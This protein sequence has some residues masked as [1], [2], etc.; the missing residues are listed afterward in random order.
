MKSTSKNNN[1]KKNIKVK[2][3][4]KTFNPKTGLFIIFI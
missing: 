1:S 4:I 2:L 3:L